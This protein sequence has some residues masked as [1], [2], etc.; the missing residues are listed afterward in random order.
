M[1]TPHA[2]VLRILATALALTTTACFYDPP[3]AGDGSSGSSTDADD[4]GDDGGSISTSGAATIT[5]ADASDDGA[6]GSSPATTGGGSGDGSDD[7]GVDASS[8][9]GADTGS[10][11][12]T[13]AADTTGG[14]ASTD[15]STGEPDASRVVFVL[16]GAGA[17][18]NY[19]G[20]AGADAM[21]RAAADAAALDGTFFA[22]LSDTPANDPDARFVHEGGPFVR[23]DGV[24]IADDWADL[25]DGTLAAPI[26]VDASGA[27]ID[28]L[29]QPTGWV[30][31]HT[32]A[33]GTHAGGIAPCQ[34][35]TGPS[36]VQ[37]DRGDAAVVDA[38]WSSADEGWG[39]DNDV[40]GGPSLY[41]FAQ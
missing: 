34:G 11:A 15:A 39:C 23:P 18:M 3:A 1:T 28:V 32:H 17:P 4:G 16:V 19:G 2:P 38:G 20:L 6:D 26:D 14:D 9:A 10:E 37:P 25:T 41:C 35:Y 27:T 36:L 33:D 13:G 24:V 29:D 40:L 8:S 5:S 30:I 31:T 22:W 21:C 12:S 7:A